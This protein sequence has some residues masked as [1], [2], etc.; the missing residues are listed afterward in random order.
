[1]DSDVTDSDLVERVRNGDKQ[2]FNLLVAKYQYKIQNLISRFIKDRFEQE[3]VTQEAFIKAY[4]AI[5]NFR[6]DSAFYTWLYR[7]AV[8]TAKNHLV[9]AGR[10]PPAQGVEL[11][12]G[13]V[14]G[15]MDGL[16][17]LNSPEAI[18]QNDE[19]VQVIRNAIQ[20]L[21]DEL[22]EAVTLRE[23]DGLSYEDI[24]KVMGCPIGTVRSRI[25]RAREAIEQAMEAP[26]K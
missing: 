16:T 25:F 6:G 26:L 17:E 13:A 4:R 23:F 14:I 24:A 2:A 1:M 20:A 15:A 12:D 8:N 21:P 11:D 7:I 5:A 18:L 10:R 19:L 9:G 3:D 22:H